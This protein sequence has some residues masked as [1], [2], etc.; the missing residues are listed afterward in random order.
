MKNLYKGMFRILL[1]VLLAPSLHGQPMVSVQLQMPARP[2]PYFS[3]WTDGSQ[4]IQVV[5]V[6]ESDMTFYAVF[7]LQAEKDGVEVLRTNLDAMP[8]RLIEPGVEVVE[9]AEFIIP[10]ALSLHAEL[11]ETLARTGKFPAGTY[12][13]CIRIFDLEMQNWISETACQIVQITDYQPPVLIQPFDGQVF[14]PNQLPV[15]QYTPVQPPV[16]PT[17][18]MYPVYYRLVVM[19]VHAGQSPLDAFMSNFPVMELFLEGETQAFWLPDF[20]DPIPGQQYV[21]SAQAIDAMEQPIGQNEGWAGPMVF[22]IQEDEPPLVMLSLSVFSED[23]VPVEGAM[24]ILNGEEYPP[25]AAVFDGLPAGDY[26]LVVVAEGYEPQT[27][28]LVLTGLEEMLEVYVNLVSLETIADAD[29]EA[30]DPLVGVEPDPETDPDA[31][32]DT[33]PDP[34]RVTEAPVIGEPVADCDCT[35][36]VITEIGVSLDGAPMTVSADNPLVVGN[37][38][39]FIP[40]VVSDCPEDCPFSLT[41]QASF[42]TYDAN[43]GLI[44]ESTS[45]GT[46]SVSYRPGRSG[47]LHVNVEAVAK[48]GDAECACSLTMVFPLE[49]RTV[50]EGLIRPADEPGEEEPPDTTETPP[51]VADPAERDEKDPPIITRDPPP[52]EYPPHRPEDEACFPST[53]QDPG[54]PIVLN[55]YLE[56][57]GKFPYP[58]AVPLHAIG[59]DW[60]FIY[61]NCHDCDQSLTRYRYP[62]MDKV[63]TYRWELEGK[64]SLNLPF[65]AQR[66]ME[67]EERIE[68]LLK[69]LAEKQKEKQDIEHLIATLPADMEARKE[70]A[71]RQIGEIEALNALIE[72]EL[73]SLRGVHADR[74]SDMDEMASLMAGYREKMSDLR[75]RIAE[76]VEDLDEIREQLQNHPTEEEKTQRE[77]L[78]TLRE[79]LEDLAEAIWDIEQGIIDRNEEL[80]AA[81]VQA[82]EELQAAANDYDTLNLEIQSTQ[83]EI[84]GVFREVYQAPVNVT[85]ANRQSYW[86]EAADAMMTYLGDSL[87]IPADSLE[88]MAM[89]RNEVSHRGSRLMFTMDTLERQHA[90]QSLTQLTS[91]FIY[92]ADLHCRTQP[93]RTDIRPCLGMVYWMSQ[94]NTPFQA[95]IASAVESRP[96]FTPRHNHKLDS[97]RN[98]LFLYESQIFGLRSRVEEKNDQLEDALD[99]FSRVMTNL[100]DEKEQAIRDRDAKEAERMA[101]QT[102]LNE[103]I[104][105][106]EEAFAANEPQLRAQLFTTD[107]LKTREELDL[108]RLRTLLGRQMADSTL[109]QQ[110]LDLLDEEILRLEE[111]LEANERA[112]ASLEK[113][114]EIDVDAMMD[115]L[116][117]K[118]EELEGEIADLEEELK[119]LQEEIDRLMG[120]EQKSA[121]GPMVYYIPPPLEE[122]MKD[123]ERFEELKDEVSEAEVEYM[124]ALAFKGELQSSFTALLEGIARSLHAAKVADASLDSL[125]QEADVAAEAF[126]EMEEEKKASWEAEKEKA[127]EALAQEQEKLRNL[128]QSEQDYNQQVSEARQQK[129]DLEQQLASELADFRQLSDELGK[130]RMAVDSLERVFSR[131]AVRLRAL[132]DSVG[133]LT[134]RIDGERQ[135]LE[136]AGDRL[137]RAVSREDAEQEAAA[138]DQIRSIR[139]SLESFE[140]GLED[141]QTRQTQEAD[142][143][144]QTVV[145]LESARQHYNSRQLE[146]AE[147]SNDIAGLRDELYET[148]KALL[149]SGELLM[150]TLRRKSRSEG[151]VEDLEKQVDGFPGLSEALGD[152]AELQDANQAMVAGEQAKTNAQDQKD[153]SIKAMEE[154]LE[155]KQRLEEEAKERMESAIERREKAESELRAFLLEEFNQVEFADTLYITAKDDVIDGWRSPDDSVRVMAVIRYNLGRVPELVFKENPVPAP[156]PEYIV[157]GSCELD[158]T[159]LPG[160][161]IGP[162]PSVVV[163]P[164]PRTIALV[165]ENGKPLWPEWPV[166]PQTGKMLAESV[167][168]VRAGGSDSDLFL[169]LCS[170]LTEDCDDPP[171]VANPVRDLLEFSWS[172]EGSFFNQQDF[173]EYVLWEPGLVDK[174][175]CDKDQEFMTMYEARTIEADPRVNTTTVVNIEP[176]IMIEVTDSLMGYPDLTRDVVARIV[177]GNYQGLAGETIEFSVTLTDGLS[178]DW[179]FGGDTLVTVQTDGLGYARAPFDFG[180]GFARFAFTA[181]WIREEE[182]PACDMKQFLAES[183]LYLK[184]HYV[185]YSV[186]AAVRE[187]AKEIWTGADIEGVIGELDD[188]PE[189]KPLV[190]VAGLMDH[191]RE[192]VDG[193]NLH[194]SLEDDGSGSSGSNGGSN[195]GSSGNNGVGNGNNGVGGLGLDPETEETH[196]FGIADTQV[197]GEVEEGM[198]VT[199][200]VQPD[201]EYLAVCIPPED[202]GTFS[203]ARIDRFKI[204]DEDDL[205][206]ILVDEPFSPYEPVSG[207]GHLAVTTGGMVILMLRDLELQISDVFLEARGDDYVA[208]DGRVSWHAEAG[209]GLDLLGFRFELDSLVILPV[210]GGGIGGKVNHS[211]LSYPVRFYAEIGTDGDFFGEVLELPEIGMGDFKLHKGTHLVIDWSNERSVGG[212]ENDFKGIVIRQATLDMPAIFRSSDSAEPSTLQAQDF[213]IG[214]SGVHGTISLYGAPL[215]IGYAGFELIGDSISLTFEHSE[216]RDFGIRGIFRFPEPVEG[217]IVATVGRQG[218]AG[219]S[220]ELETENPVHIPKLKTTLAL[221]TGTRFDWDESS[222]T[223]TVTINA[224]VQSEHFSDVEVIGLQVDNK[225]LFKAEAIHVDTGL[226]IGGGF[227]LR[228]TTVSFSIG[229]EEEDH[230]KLDGSL[231]IDLMAEASLTG[232]LILMAGPTVDFVFE[233]ATIAFERGPVEFQGSFAYNSREFKGVFDIDIKNL[234]GLKGMLV[235]GTMPVDEEQTYSY[236]YA[237]LVLKASVPLGQTGLA[238]MELGGGLGFNYQPPIGSEDGSPVNN[239]QFSLK[240]LIGLGNATPP[241]GKVFM[242]RMELV[243]MPGL[244]ALNGKA[245]VLDKENSVF[246]EGRLNLR[247]EPETRVDG[248][249]RSYIALADAD[250]KIF[251]F[252]GKINYDFHPGGF[253]IQSEEISGMV[254]QKV[255][256]EAS[257]LFTP[258]EVNLEG[259]VYFDAGAEQG[260]GIVTVK[261]FVHTQAGGRLNYSHPTSSLSAKVDLH[262]NWGADLETPIGDYV[263]LRGDILLEAEIDATP[264]QIDLRANASVS[265]SILWYTGSTDVA[266]GYRI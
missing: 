230:L 247:W 60:D 92:L 192:F 82:R 185:G 258:E 20:D 220:L 141:L 9:A 128:G 28:S 146:V 81:I 251:R 11:G 71:R 154:A 125:E 149:R 175:R 126:K 248:F 55:V 144:Q 187:G 16:D 102:S 3:D 101:A 106:R 135:A 216:I 109:L 113:I 186:D 204:G 107:S 24:V 69:V 140:D 209:V 231:G 46:G 261:A 130:V 67:L 105:A 88:P 232:S 95:A 58:R 5:V 163:G 152:D 168:K 171:Q 49:G 26:E 15:F 50:A 150:E 170:S 56:E 19:E 237:E 127:E 217:G 100:E 249:V 43:G 114:L 119:Q 195:G 245:W 201:E 198:V 65:S 123:R 224:R 259:R 222:E 183:P 66:I 21:W 226:K 47:E 180:D 57:N 240:A 241:Q 111:S 256:G 138:R 29:V 27:L 1:L 53:D 99:E 121:D 133:M 151:R 37:E 97:L 117:G 260:L 199:V 164:E 72:A 207:T 35:E 188:P 137:T 148:N 162:S 63:S 257:V 179:G 189:E 22:S 4:Q 94:V 122:V 165:Y 157:E 93:P 17:S 166:I 243:L 191:N 178:S 48:C 70:R 104:A 212:L 38:Y 263:I 73:D 254:F 134:A 194:F 235:V 108:D 244:F 233:E 23:G 264:R 205:F 120:G 156:A 242:G 13:F 61:F 96:D 167:L 252:N 52:P 227:D 193:K 139:Q 118:K 181:K 190:A 30:E 136:A 39:A 64:G 18:S 124:E 6:N 208:I 223:G 239:D 200:S 2:S 112:I 44:A 182:Q 228:V 84:N 12:R 25:G 219:W 80:Q 161:G 221:N 41:I 89:I 253:L 36:C 218:N 87:H 210:R 250:G 176:G 32:P 40:E 266:F 184:M 33:E 238:L 131:Q 155:E 160:A 59:I 169:H 173:S 31:E 158:L 234:A 90:S 78:K 79:S 8:P 211:V 196:L 51:G 45:T 98:V 262:G 153:R 236:W 116:E 177:K 14:S 174:P 75:D 7:S 215:Q 68:E 246:G 147:K 54:L 85:M 110:D 206:E 265:W 255:K 42:R 213:A 197:T 86:I 83:Q 132:T 143:Q 10:D 202:S 62:V 76:L 225:G 91:Q 142:S 214:S 77:L 172:G 203:T 129:D 159:E 103:M 115:E 145:A 229:G 74:I 34:E